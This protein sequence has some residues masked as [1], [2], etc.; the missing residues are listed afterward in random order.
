MHA[1]QTGDRIASIRAWLLG[2]GRRAVSLKEL[3]H[4]FAEQLDS[5]GV[6]V[7]R[8]WVGNDL[9]HPQARVYLITWE[10]GLDISEEFGTYIQYAQYVQRKDSPQVHLRAGAPWVRARRVELTGGEHHEFPV[11]DALFVRGFT[12]YYALPLTCR[13]DYAGTI[14]W[15]TRAADG[16]ENATIEVLNGVC[17]V[18]DAVNEPLAR[19]LTAA[20]LMRTYLGPNA[21]EQVLTGQVRRGDGQ[22]IRAAIWFGDLRGFTQLSETIEHDKLLSLLNDT[23]ELV[24]ERLANRGGEV[25]K[26]IGDGALAIFPAAD[27]DPDGQHACQAAYDASR[28]VLNQ[29]EH[30]RAQRHAV[31]LPV[32]ALGIGLHYGDVYYGNIGA[33]SRLDFTVIGKA[34]NVAARVEGMCARLG[35]PILASETFARRCTGETVALEP[36]DLKGVAQPI[37]LYAIEP[38]PA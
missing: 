6:Q 30:V 15:A 35:R 26:F 18:F 2:D 24:V 32:A 17:P 11:V 3:T 27:D 19:E 14:S 7:D 8:I 5:H 29:L 23:F 20:T 31:G 9:L 1:L 12:D 22:T 36:M 38:T 16:F 28:D 25:L 4:G 13:G 37:M 33:L 10:R 34:V 21:A